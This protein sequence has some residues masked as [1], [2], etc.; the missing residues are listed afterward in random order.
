MFIEPTNGIKKYKGIAE[1]LKQKYKIV[2]SEYH[3]IHRLNSLRESF[4][5]VCWLIRLNDKNNT[6]TITMNIY[7]STWIDKF[8]CKMLNNFHLNIIQPICVF[9]V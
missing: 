7:D 1:I 3:S 4:T 5:N 9:D 8:F 2:R 6:E